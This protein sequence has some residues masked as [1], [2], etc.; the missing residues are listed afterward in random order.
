MAIVCEGLGPVRIKGVVGDR[1]PY[2]TSAGAKAILAFT[3]PEHRESILSHDLAAVTPHS[4]NT[5]KELEKEL[6]EIRRQGFAFDRQENNLGIQAF[7]T[8]IFNHAGEPVAAVV[9]AGAAQNVTLGKKSAFCGHAQ[10]RLF[11]DRGPTLYYQIGG[12]RTA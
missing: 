5:R 6:E 10:R 8:P 9:I 3:N 1:H 11:Q 12:L 2:H 7:G 4:K